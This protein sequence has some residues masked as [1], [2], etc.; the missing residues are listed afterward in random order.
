MPPLTAEESEPTCV[1]M[2]TADKYTRRSS[3]FNEIKRDVSRRGAAPRLPASC[4][5]PS[6]LEAEMTLAATWATEKWRRS[7]APA[8]RY[9]V[10]NN[11][12]GC[13]GDES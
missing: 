8:D 2:V 1:H 9:V 12:P 4:P 3:A 5:F 11:N 13:C 10:E 7:G 6:D